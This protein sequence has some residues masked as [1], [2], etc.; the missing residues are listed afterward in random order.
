MRTPSYKDPSTQA[1]QASSGHA[2]ANR[3][4]PLCLAGGS[5]Q[6]L[7]LHGIIDDATGEVIAAAFRPTETLEG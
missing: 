2:V 6:Q 1:S 5:C 7:T 4:F 3:C